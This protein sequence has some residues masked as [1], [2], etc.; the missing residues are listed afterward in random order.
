MVDYGK[1]KQ[2]IS[3]I[4]GQV[5]SLPRLLLNYHG[6]LQIDHIDRNRLN[7]HKYNLRLATPA[8]NLQNRD[9]FK[10][11]GQRITTS[12][13]K[14][15]TYL[16]N[17]KCWK[18]QMGYQGNVIYLGCYRTEIEAAIVY[19]IYASKYFGEFAKLNELPEV[20]TPDLLNTIHLEN[21]HR[22]IEV[23]AQRIIRFDF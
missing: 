21:L 13:Y 6:D 19:N 14:G 16:W 5:I 4:N 2:I 1:K 8:Q 15:V 3:S 17:N 7:N 10:T 22:L 20:I 18:S 9:K 12:R 11:Y 23:F